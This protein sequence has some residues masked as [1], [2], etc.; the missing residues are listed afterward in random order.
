MALFALLKGATTF[1][2]IRIWEDDHIAY[3]NPFSI[4]ILRSF[5]LNLYQL[6]F[7]KYK[8]EKVLFGSKPTMANI[9]HSCR[10][11][12]DIVSDLFEL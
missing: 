9:G 3:I 10:Y 6:Y 8:N 4:S 12:D 7:N 2:E 11:D 5:A 1:K